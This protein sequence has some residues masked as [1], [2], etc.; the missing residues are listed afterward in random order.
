MYTHGLLNT[1]SRPRYASTYLSFGKCIIS[2]KED[3]T[4]YCYILLQLLLIY[5]TIFLI[6]NLISGTHFSVQEGAL[7]YKYIVFLITDSFH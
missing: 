1:F 3:T 7:V 4:V 2:S 5:I 6:I